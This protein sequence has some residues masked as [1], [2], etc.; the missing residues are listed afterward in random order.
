[1]DGSGTKT[2][3]DPRRPG[4]PILKR[5]WEA[6]G[7]GAKPPTAKSK[8][9]SIRKTQPPLNVNPGRSAF[10][11]RVSSECMPPSIA[12]QKAENARFCIETYGISAKWEQYPR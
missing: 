7:N 1:V 8:G 2:I 3:R 6:N 11:Q 5:W 4:V 9:R 10:G 12:A